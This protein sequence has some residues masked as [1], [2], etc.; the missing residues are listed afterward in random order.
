[1]MGRPGRPALTGGNYSAR[2]GSCRACVDRLPAPA[3]A[4]ERERTFLI[5]GA[6]RTRTTFPEQVKYY[7]TGEFPFALL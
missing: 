1:L 6:K 2:P 4:Q 7:I 5:I 3:S